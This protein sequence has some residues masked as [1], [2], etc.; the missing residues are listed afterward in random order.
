MSWLE[1]MGIPGPFAAVLIVLGAAGLT[2]GCFQP[3]YGTQTATGTPDLR[4]KLAAVEVEPIDAPNGSPQARVAVELRNALLFNLTGGSGTIAP[5]HKLTVRLSLTRSAVIVDTT[6]ARPE[7]E[8]AGIDATYSLRDLATG[9]IAVTGRTF[10]RLS[11]DIPG[12]QQRFARARGQRD[13]QDR[14]AKVIADQIH[15]RLASFFVTGS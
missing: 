15:L 8:N 3:L 6:S 5:T 2:G 1:R 12:Q 13:A 4:N 11:Y 10:S 9:K 7:V 14:A